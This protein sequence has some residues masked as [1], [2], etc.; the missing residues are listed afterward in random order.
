MQRSAESGETAGSLLLVMKN[1]REECFLKTGYADIEAKKPLERNTL[2]R[3]Y[4]MTKPVTAA[5]VM[6]LVE[7]GLI[8]LNDQIKYIFPKSIQITVYLE[9]EKRR[10]KILWIEKQ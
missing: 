2:F 5:A 10:E 6:I 4:S 7:R 9:D 8:D 1:G 3:L